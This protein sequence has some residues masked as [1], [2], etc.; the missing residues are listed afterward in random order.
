MKINFIEELGFSGRAVKV[1]AAPVSPRSQKEVIDDV[2]E[3][4]IDSVY[5]SQGENED[6][7]YPAIFIRKVGSF[8]ENTL[9]QITKI[10]RKAWNYKK[11]SFLYVHSDTEIRIYNCVETP[12]FERKDTNYAEELKSKELM[13]CKQSDTQQLETL[14]H[15]FSLMAIDSGLIWTAEEAA[16]IRKKIDTQQRVDKFLVESLTNITKELMNELNTDLI[17]RLIL[18][19][20]FLLYLEDRGAADENFYAK[21]Q[22]GAKSYFD[23]LRDINA[24][25]SLFGKLETHF[26]GN[27]FSVVDGEIK[28]VKQKHLN[29]IRKC[30][31]SGYKDPCQMDLFDDWRLFDF[32][33][34]QIELISQIYEDFLAAVV[35]DKKKNFG[36]FYT[37]LSLVELMLNEKLSINAKEKQYELKILDPACGSGIFLVESFKRLVKRYE[38]AHKKKLMDFETLKK[39]LVDNIFGIE[40]D[41]N[42]IKV[43]A[44]S[45]YLALVDCLNP[46]TLWQEKGKLLPNLINDPDDKTLKKQGRNLYKRDTFEENKEIERIK[47]DLV[48]G[49]PPFGTTDLPNSIRNYCDEHKFAK[50]MVLPFLHK[51]AEFA[52]NGEIVMIFNTKVLT[53]TGTTYQNFR[54]WLMQDCY[55]EKIYNFSILRRATKNFGGQLFGDAVGPISIVFYRKERPENPSNRIIYY[56]PKTYVKSNVLDGIVIDSTDKKFLPRE[57]CEKPN[58][59]IW[60]IAMWGGTA[61][62]ELIKRINRQASSNLQQFLNKQKLEIK[63]GLHGDRN[64]TDFVPDK[65]IQTGA[66]ERYYTS[67]NA[68]ITNKKYYREI[69][70]NLFRPPYVAIKKGRKNT[71]ITASLITHHAYC[72]NGVYIINNNAKNNTDI[73]KLL[74]SFINSDIVTY[75]LFLTA[76]SWGIEREQTFLTEYLELPYLFDNANLKPLVAQFDL[77][78]KELQKDFPNEIEVEKMK[79]KVNN[80]LW[81]IINIDAHDRIHIQDTLKYSLD[82]FEKQQKSQAVLPVVD[83]KLYAEMLCSVLNDFFDDNNFF[84]NATIYKVSKNNPLCLIKV[85]FNKNKRQL[86]NSKEMVGDELKKLEPQLWEKNVNNIYFR[87][88]LNYANGDDIFIIRPNQRRFWCQSAAMEDATVLILECLTQGE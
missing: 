88:S 50:E 44:F 28:R 72:K 2:R 85:S 52:P 80:E 73:K 48:V 26:N 53:N 20:L 40:C 55:V 46:K 82:L 25:Y 16:N 78:M 87:K 6:D 83:T 23:I 65:I 84:A 56:A 57:E 74:V 76:A 45:L 22:K 71:E 62:F 63:T 15:I 49:N 21:I 42:A 4:G 29:I 51:S 79:D 3:F 12:V 17:H 68:I 66:I 8:D 30:F 58:T 54:K 33:I 38:N 10:H 14:R 9:K 31:I 59:Q 27:V 18:R 60:K 11:V 34:I 69:D 24:T 36:V 77:L 39:L 86:I 35:P 41:S 7:R 1:K 32:S 19:S 5:F 43:A 67:K 70:K 37:P 75:Y 64:H 61:D 81:K 47:F 13:V